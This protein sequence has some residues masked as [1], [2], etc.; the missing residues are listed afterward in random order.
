MELAGSGYAMGMFAESGLGALF[1]A[2][3][4][5]LV[6]AHHLFVDGVCGDGICPKSHMEDMQWWQWASFNGT[7]GT[8]HSRHSTSFLSSSPMG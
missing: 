6:P 4:A 8:G 1:C 7:H 5:Q 2:H 3:L